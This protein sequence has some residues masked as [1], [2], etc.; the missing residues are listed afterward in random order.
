MRLKAVIV[1]F[2]SRKDGN[3]AKIGKLINENIQD[4]ILFSFS[5]FSIQTCGECNYDCFK[6][7]G[8]CPYVG[9][10]ECDM[11]DSIVQSEIAYFVLPNYCDYPCANYFAFN[12]R[13]QCYFQGKPDLLNAY[14]RIPKRSIVVSN[15]NE[16]NFIKA[17][18]YQTNQDPVVLFLSAKQY[19]KSSI[20]GDL[21]T[22][23]KAVSD[24]LEFIGKSF[25]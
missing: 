7:R 6:K 1:S 9:D 21:L 10:M 17:L 11:L 25:Q 8:K 23:E 14:L 18:S 16:E 2:S 5:D 12:E 3:C 15:T 24:I 22:N 20:Q 13:S 19:G 4:S